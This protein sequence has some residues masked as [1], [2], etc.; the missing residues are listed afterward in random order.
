MRHVR[1]AEPLLP[2]DPLRCRGEGM[3]FRVQKRQ[4]VDGPKPE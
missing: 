4:T 3:E 1:K 2:G